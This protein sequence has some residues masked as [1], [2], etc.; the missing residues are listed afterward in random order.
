MPNDLTF[1]DPAIN[2]RPIKVALPA[3]PKSEKPSTFMGKLREVL[4]GLILLAAFFAA[5]YALS[6][7]IKLHGK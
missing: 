3:Q 6:V 4:I 7:L 1:N 2:P 5:L